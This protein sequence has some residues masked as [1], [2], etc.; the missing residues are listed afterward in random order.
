[1]SGPLFIILRAFLP[2]MS[3]FEH[4]VE[5][6]GGLLPR[7]L[8]EE[9]VPLLFDVLHVGLQVELLRFCHPLLVLKQIGRGGRRLGRINSSRLRISVVALCVDRVLARL[10]NIIIELAV[11]RYILRIVPLAFV[12]VLRF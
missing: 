6:V 12:P 2:C 1:M 4:L 9:L 10:K 3:E 7:L 8:E 11:V 5:I